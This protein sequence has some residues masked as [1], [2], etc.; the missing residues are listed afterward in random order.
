MTADSTSPSYEKI[1]DSEKIRRLEA[2]LEARIPVDSPHRQGLS[3]ADLTEA[4]RKLLYRYNPGNEIQRG[5]LQQA[6]EALREDL[7][8]PLAEDIE[9]APAKEESR[10]EIEAKA[11]EAFGEFLQRESGFLTR[12]A[13][14]VAYARDYAEELRRKN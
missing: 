10:S 7:P 13:P 4:L 2:E 5:A 9:A 3:R 6:L 14:G 1:T 8:A 12:D 11:V